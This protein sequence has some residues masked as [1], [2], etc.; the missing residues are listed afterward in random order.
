MACSTDGKVVRPHQFEPSAGHAENTPREYKLVSVS[1]ICLVSLVKAVD[2]KTSY[3][4]SQQYS[5][6]DAVELSHICSNTQCK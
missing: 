2:H 5:I 4:G 6:H 1:Q 3:S